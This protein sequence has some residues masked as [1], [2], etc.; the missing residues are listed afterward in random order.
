MRI[1]QEQLRE[2]AQILYPREWR[3]DRSSALVATLKY[4]NDAAIEFETREVVAGSKRQKRV[5]VPEKSAEIT[6]L[7]TH[8]RNNHI[9]ATAVAKAL[10][11]NPMTLYSWFHGNSV[12]KAENLV[13]IRGFLNKMNAAA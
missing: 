11:V 8:I 2:A 6:D 1:T 10:E 13:K 3:D 7:E 5:P 9:H 12:P 4:L